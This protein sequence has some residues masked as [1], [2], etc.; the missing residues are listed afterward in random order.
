MRATPPYL[1]SVRE[2]RARL[3]SGSA[4]YFGPSV[5]NTNR[6]GITCT[7][8]RVPMAKPASS[9]QRPCKRNVGIEG[10]CRNGSLRL[11]RPLLLH[12]VKLREVFIKAA[13]SKKLSSTLA[14]K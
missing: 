1:Q 11:S 14:T 8:T 12:I 6:P 3:T 5:S 7:P 13:P 4:A 9:S 10:N 2:R